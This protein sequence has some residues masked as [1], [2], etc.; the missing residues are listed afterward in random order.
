MVKEKYK[1]SSDIKGELFRLRLK[2]VKE[3][4]G[5]KFSGFD[6]EKNSLLIKDYLI[7]RDL[8][9]SKTLLVS[10]ELEANKVFDNKHSEVI[11]N[12]EVNK[13]LNFITEITAKPFVEKK[14]I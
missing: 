8:I 4:I 10:E 1:D 13:V 5:N 12:S 6:L 7:L 9:V 11:D 14:R 3:Q 2:N